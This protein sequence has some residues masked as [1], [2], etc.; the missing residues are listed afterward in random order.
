MNQIVIACLVFLAG[1]ALVHPE[2]PTAPAMTT[3]ASGNM[4]TQLALAH[5]ENATTAVPTDPL[6]N[7]TLPV[8]NMTT[9]AGT[10]AP[11]TGKSAATT[12]TCEASATPMALFVLACALLGL[13]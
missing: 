8:A 9:A 12:T 10:V 13:E 3:P 11:T 2:K 4:T 5:S 7:K 6:E 1:V